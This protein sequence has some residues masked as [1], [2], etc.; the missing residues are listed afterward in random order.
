MD[1]PIPIIEFIC[2]IIRKARVLI[3]RHAP[4]PIQKELLKASAY[5][6]EFYVFQL[7]QLVYPVIRAGNIDMGDQNS[8]ASMAKYYEA[9]NSLREIGYIEQVEGNFF[10]L[11]PFGLK[12]AR[13]MN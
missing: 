10:R 6:G 13:K 1:N 3:K 2:K 9:F 12:K 5:S 7:D 8:S 4:D 11:T